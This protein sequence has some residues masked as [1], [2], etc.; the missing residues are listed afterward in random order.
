MTEALSPP[1]SS[2]P[3][4]GRS[5]Q[6]GIGRVCRTS[7][8]VARVSLTSVFMLAEKV[9]VTR[10]KH[11][12]GFKSFRRLGRR[13][14]V[15]MANY[16][17]L[18]PCEPIAFGGFPMTRVLCLLTAIGCLATLPGCS[19]CFGNNGCRRPSFMEFRNTGRGIYRHECGVPCDPCQAAPCCEPCGSPAPCC[20]GV[21]E[22][23]TV[24]S[25]GQVTTEP[26]TFS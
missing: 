3:A 25:P 1:G 21:M 16:V 22:G 13:L 12:V 10:P 5:N 20:E 8:T 24:I 4:R 26:G 19:S 7:P 17:Q 2:Q 23:G 18:P 15:V 14:P 9:A 11:G 6:C